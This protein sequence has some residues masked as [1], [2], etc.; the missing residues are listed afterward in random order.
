MDNPICD[1][2]GCT[3]PTRSPKAAWC[4][5]HYFRWYRN[6]DPNRLLVAE[7]PTTC[8]VEGCEKPK[9]GSY[10]RMHGARLERNGDP[11]AL[12]PKL[13]GTTATYRVAHTWVSQDRGKAS[14][15]ECVHC[16]GQA[17]QWAYDHEDHA[18]LVSPDGYRYSLDVNRY[19]PLC[20][21]CHLAFDR[22]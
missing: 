1:I 19:I 7:R 2:A 11:L 16:D 14:G 20:V 5:T 3:R 4:N 18:E 10:C 9:R 13:R 8:T 6:G 21:S 15:Y 22:H 12:N 17:K